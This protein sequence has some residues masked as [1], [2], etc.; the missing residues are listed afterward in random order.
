MLL[1][2]ALHL[3]DFLIK[4]CQGRPEDDDKHDENPGDAGDIFEKAVFRF[5]GHGKKLGASGEAGQ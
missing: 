5:F 1:L 2:E 3:P 4:R